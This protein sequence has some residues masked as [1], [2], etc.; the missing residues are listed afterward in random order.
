MLENH[1]E[2]A[3]TANDGRALIEAAKRLEPD[4]V[5]VDIS[6]PGL[7]GIDAA[8]EIR[9]A[10]PAV[11]LIFL[12]MHSDGLYLRK[13]LAAGASGYVLKSGAAE[14]LLSCIAAV[15]KG[16]T[17]IS[18]AFAEETVRRARQWRLE[19]AHGQPALTERQKEILRLLALGK[20][21]KEVAQLTHISVR[22]VEFHRNRIMSLLGA[23]GVAELTRHAIQL[24][25]ID[26]EP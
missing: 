10:Q 19:R 22:T 1:Y 18:P 15:Q 26:T 2:L 20:H 5:V 11:K 14:E 12:T 16:E 9:A 6:M 4:V 25:L 17:Y 13:A 3:G 21:N 7:N 8:R 24:G 23:A